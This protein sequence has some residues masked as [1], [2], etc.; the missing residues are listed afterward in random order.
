VD[1]SAG[2]TAEKSTTTIIVR[3]YL[4]QQA[5]MRAFENDALDL[6]LLDTQLLSGYT[7]RSSLRIDHF[8][9]PEILFMSCNTR[10]RQTLAD[11]KK[12]AKIKQVLQDM[13]QSS[14]AFSD[15]AETSSLGFSAVSWLGQQVGPSVADILA[16][17]ESDW[18][19]QE[20]TLLLIVPE[21]DARRVRLA[22][23]AADFLSRAG[24]SCSVS[25]LAREQFWQDLAAGRYDLALM[26]VQMPVK[27][28]PGFLVQEP[29]HPLF[30]GLAA[31]RDSGAGL[32]DESLWR[33]TW[34][35]THPITQLS[36][37]MSEAIDTDWLMALKETTARS[38]WEILCLPYMG[39]VYGNRVNGQ[40]RP[41]R[42]H[43]YDNIEELWIWSGQSSSSS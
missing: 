39:L 41:N 3:E 6:I 2:S 10:N 28:Q 38:P 21:Q 37:V 9:G 34:Q 17:H 24:I 14:K 29:A 15:W 27:P 20:T 25:S 33:E 35:Q 13:K 42:Y 11:E 31:I 32:S 7:V 5:A 26:T 8:T 19:E 22:H 36:R 12:L 30:A 40:S 23:E 16:E 18:S 1:F 43:P 4:N